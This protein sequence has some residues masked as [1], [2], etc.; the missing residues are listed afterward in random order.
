MSQK[1]A[2]IGVPDSYKKDASNKI[3]VLWKVKIKGRS[4]LADDIPLHMSLRVFDKLSK[5][6]MEKVKE[7][8]KEF[9]VQT[10]DSKN[11]KFKTTIFHSRHTGKDYYMLKITGEDANLHRFFEYFKDGYGFS[12]KAFM[13]HITI[14][15]DLYDRINKDGLEPDEIEFEALS[16]EDGADNSVH[17][18][19]KSEKIITM[20]KSEGQLMENKGMQI[21]PQEIDSV[22]EAGLLNET[23]VRLI[24]T[25]GGFWIAVGRP[26]GKLREEA[27]SAGSHPAIVKYNLER[28]YPEF[29]PHMMKSEMAESVTVDKHS[30]FLSEDLIKS[31]HDIFSISSPTQIEFQITKHNATIHSVTAILEN[32]S[33]V[34]KNM[35]VD[36]KFTRALAGAASEKALKFGAHKIK[37]QKG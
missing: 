33:L 14:D 23:P 13:P 24:R 19:E 30:R 4:Y 17:E 10:P 1:K 32:N 20:K 26:K 5:E 16:I 25:R 36:P 27:L 37:I 11:L 15:K 8:V 3:D 21:N 18:F 22:E 34:F 6:D 9:D 31:G 7:K 28:Q 2:G 29:Q 35:S 12:H